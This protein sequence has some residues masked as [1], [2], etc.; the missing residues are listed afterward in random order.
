[1]GYAFINF[2]DPK[3]IIKF[4]H[5]WAGR[6]WPLLYS[7][8]KCELAYGRIQGK[9]ALMEHFKNS[10]TLLSAPPLC[11]PMIFVSQAEAAAAPAAPGAEAATST[12]SAEAAEG[13]EAAAGEAAAPAAAAEDDGGAAAA[14]LAPEG[15]N[16]EEATAA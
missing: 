15:Q 4:H 2:T 16:E 1:M 12:P 7:R 8:K 9:M 5:A 3:S 10:R 11:R 13:G 6:R 14:E